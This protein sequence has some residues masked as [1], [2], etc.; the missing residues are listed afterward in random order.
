MVQILALILTSEQLA[1]IWEDSSQSHLKD[2][3]VVVAVTIVIMKVRDWNKLLQLL[4]HL[5]SKSMRCMLNNRNKYKQLPAQSTTINKRQK[6]KTVNELCSYYER[7]MCYICH[8]CCSKATSIQEHN[9]QVEDCEAR[10]VCPRFEDYKDPTYLKHVSNVKLWLYHT[11][12]LNL[13][14]S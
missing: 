10:Q 9:R 5:S 11:Y 6:E 1:H 2:I 8:S 14:S 13:L 4:F 12:L 3:I 7:S